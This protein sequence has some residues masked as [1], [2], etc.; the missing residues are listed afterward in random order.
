MPAEKV[1]S[2]HI[3]EIALKGKNR[4]I[5]ENRLVENIRKETGCRKIRNLRG[6]II[7][8]PGKNGSKKIEDALSR[9][10]GIS[11]YSESILTGNKPKEIISALKRNATK[12][13]SIKLETKRSYKGYSLTS[14]ELNKKVGMELEKSGFTVDLENPEERIYIGI[15]EDSAVIS[16]HKKKG[17]TGLPVGSSG[18][19]ISLLSGG[20]DSPVSSWLMMKRGCTVDFLHFHAFPTNEKAKKSKI[21]RLVKQ[22]KKYSPVKKLPS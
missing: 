16:L 13:K 9:T 11:W 19:V 5:F 20:I 12:E 22:L 18:K 2:I 4:R 3:G 6:R 1:Y 17:L 7:L 10:F 8:Y 14:M 21:I 15:L